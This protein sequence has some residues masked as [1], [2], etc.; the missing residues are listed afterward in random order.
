MYNFSLSPQLFLS[1]PLIESESAPELAQQSEKSDETETLEHFKSDT[2]NS[3]SLNHLDYYLSDEIDCW[4][5]TDDD[6]DPFNY[7]KNRCAILYPVF[8]VNRISYSSSYNDGTVALPVSIYS[9]G[10]HKLP[11]PPPFNTPPKLQTVEDVIRNNNGTEVADLRNLAVSLA[12]DSIFGKQEMIR[13]SP[14]GRKNSNTESLDKK[15]INY[16]KAV[17]RSRVPSMSE[18]RFNL[19]WPLCRGS[20]SKSSQRMCTKA[21]RKL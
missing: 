4:A 8:P 2:H 21:K 6:F 5:T 14:S 7:H 20:I 10:G 3:G 1:T 15:K 9:V 18:E 13:C 11:G 12:R 19:V 17:V 16:I